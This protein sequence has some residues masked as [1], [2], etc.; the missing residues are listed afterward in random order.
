MKPSLFLSENNVARWNAMFAEG[1]NRA[2]EHMPP[3]K[4]HSFTDDNKLGG[5]KDGYSIKATHRYN[6]YFDMVEEARK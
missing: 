2:S 5:G 6:E 3:Q 4:Y 1:R